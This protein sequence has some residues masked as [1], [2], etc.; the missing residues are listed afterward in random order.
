MFS[1]PTPD[2]KIEIVAEMNKPSSTRFKLTNRVKQYAK[3]KAYFATGAANELNVSPKAGELEPFGRD[4][5]AFDISFA[6][7]IYKKEWKG[8]LVI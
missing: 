3:F 6:P 5:T 7:T 4:G 2:D 1:P 8:K